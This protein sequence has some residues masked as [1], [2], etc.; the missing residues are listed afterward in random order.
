MTFHQQN[1]I[2]S[3][4]SAQFM[5][6]QEQ[7]DAINQMHGLVFPLRLGATLQKTTQN[8]YTPLDISLPSHSLLQTFKILKIAHRRIFAARQIHY[9]SL[10]T[11][12]Y[13]LLASLMKHLQFQPVSMCAFCKG[14]DT[15]KC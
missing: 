14:F 11:S 4:Y 2:E 1:R 15:D 5:A 9:F 6:P 10:A 8:F 3:L 12:R 13:S 7:H